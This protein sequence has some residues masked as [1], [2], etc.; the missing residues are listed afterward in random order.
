M[1]D[2]KKAMRIASII[3][4]KG[5]VGKTITTINLAHCLATQ[6]NKKVLII[7][8]DKQGNTSK[9]FGVHDYERKSLSDI[10]MC[11]A[12]IKDVVRSTEFENI[13]IIP[14]NMTLLEANK[15]VLLDSTRPQQSRIKDALA[16]VQN[17][18]DFC[19]IDN[20]PDINMSVI[21][22]LVAS[23]DVMVPVKVDNFTFDG[24]E[25]MLDQI[26]QVKK[27]Y[28]KD[29][30]FKGCFITSYRNN[31]VNS[32][33]KDILD[34]KYKMFKTRIRW[35]DKVDESTFA[36]VPIVD[37]SRRCGA[38]KDYIEFTNEYLKGI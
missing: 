29:L 35:T 23:H 16:A 36:A 34:A 37:Y 3:N 38:A 6:H 5:G 26:E 17:D 8:N 19:L 31:D 11:E 2:V 25:I 15:K 13:D 14:A 24:I 20:A 27:Y 7:D 21:N 4:L 12:G 1:A 9:F 18:Y 30:E 10:M 22:A 33:G 28:N 32:Q